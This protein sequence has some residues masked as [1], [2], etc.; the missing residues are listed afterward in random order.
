MR[1]ANNCQ[2]LESN[3][4]HEDKTKRQDHISAYRPDVEKIHTEGWEKPRFATPVL[5]FTLR[6]VGRIEVKRVSFQ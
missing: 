1:K 6:V 5:F 4:W 3:D 2:N